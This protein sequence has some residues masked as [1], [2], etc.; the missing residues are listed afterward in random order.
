MSDNSNAQTGQVVPEAAQ[1]YES[2][3]VPALFGQFPERVLNAVGLEAGDDVL[4][5]GCGTGVLARAAARRLPSSGSVTGVDVNDGMLA[6]AGRSPESVRWRTARAEHLPFPDASF[7][8]V[9]SH[10]AAMFF[11]DRDQAAAEMA[12]V[13]RPGGRVAV[14]TWAR[15]EESPGYEAMIGLLNRLIGPDAADALRA[16]FVLGSLEQLETMLTPHLTEVAV[17]RHDGE[18]R[19]ESVEAWVHTEIRGWTLAE[20]IDDDQYDELLIA[21]EMELKEFVDADGRVRFPA[22]ALIATGSAARSGSAW[23]EV[24]SSES[25]LIEPFPVPR[26][27]SDRD[28][29]GGRE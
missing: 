17:D 6:V 15:V 1:T 20:M 10:F 26:R 11:T 16:P 2:F 28:E 5:V 4:D 27:R 8:R 29:A 25:R 14:V 7:D 19:F 13:Q 22:P 18:A 23:T 21:A 24:R 9:V 3:F 12:R